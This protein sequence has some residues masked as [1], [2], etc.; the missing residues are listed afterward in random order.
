M[1]QT[2]FDFVWRSL[3]ALGVSSANADDAAQQVFWVAAQKLESIVVGSER[4]FLFGTVRGVA[5]NARRA[6]ARRIET[7]DERALEH[8]VEP[9]LDPEQALAA[10]QARNLLERVLQ[11]MPEELRNVLVLFE[12]E[13]LTTPTIAEVLEI[14]PGTVASRLRRAREEFKVCVARVHISGEG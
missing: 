5:A 11:Q 2:Q 14:P 1:I 12:L 7:H 6:D 13:E 3:R 8:T 4:A 9:A 10:A